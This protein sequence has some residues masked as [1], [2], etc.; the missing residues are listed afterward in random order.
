MAQLQVIDA[1]EAGAFEGPPAAR[2]LGRGRHAAGQ[3]RGQRGKRL[4]EPRRQPALGRSQAAVA[5]RQRQA[6]GTDRIF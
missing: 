3:T 1:L 2:Q 6:V 5:R 4:V